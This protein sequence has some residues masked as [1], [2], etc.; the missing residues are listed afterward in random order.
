MAAALTEEFLLFY[1][2]TMKSSKAIYSRATLTS[3][4]VVFAAT[5]LKR[6][7]R[8]LIHITSCCYSEGSEES[9]NSFI[10]SVTDNTLILN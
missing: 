6:D 1:K 9:T 3:I 5:C 8:K 2:S 4:L 7:P 10:K